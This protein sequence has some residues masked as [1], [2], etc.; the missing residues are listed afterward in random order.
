MSAPCLSGPGAGRI[1][2]QGRRLLRAGLITHRELALLEALLWS[3]RPHGHATARASYTRLAD[4]A[5][6]ARSTVAEGLRQLEAFGL[7]KRTKT[8]LRV[9]WG[10]GVAS[11]QGVSLYRL[12]EP[13]ATEFS[14]RPVNQASSFLSLDASVSAEAEE[15]RKA[16][17]RIREARMPRLKRPSDMVKTCLGGVVRCRL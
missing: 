1:A 4:F 11:R 6:M 7:I 16:L 3:C 8:R 12:I 13:P 17:E 2:G 15:A 5:H 9:A 10:L 14:G